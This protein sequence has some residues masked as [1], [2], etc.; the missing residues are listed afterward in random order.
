MENPR[1]EYIEQLW[2]IVGECEIDDSAMCDPETASR[3]IR[4][5]VKAHPRKLFPE[6]QMSRGNPQWNYSM[7]LPVKDS[8]NVECLNCGVQTE[9][10]TGLA[11]SEY[12]AAKCVNCGSVLYYPVDAEW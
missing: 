2:E 5:V 11:T 10:S 7:A 9:V 1:Q 3:M 6:V 8:E 12:T 4:L